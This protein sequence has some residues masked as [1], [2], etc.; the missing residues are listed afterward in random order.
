MSSVNFVIISDKGV[1]VD[2]EKI[3]AIR[4]WFIPTNVGQIRS[5]H[6][7]TNFY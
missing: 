4:N 7:F 6:G 1:Q 5:F 2:Q 3:K